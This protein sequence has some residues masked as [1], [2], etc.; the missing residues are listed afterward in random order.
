M[1]APCCPACSRAALCATGPLLSSCW[2][3]HSH[4]QPC[5]QI[6]GYS[7]ELQ[8]TMAGRLPGAAPY[9]GHCQRYTHALP[10]TPQPSPGT[11][12]ISV[13]PR[14]SAWPSCCRTCPPPSAPRSRGCLPL[15][16]APAASAWR[17]GSTSGTSTATSDELQSICNGSQP[18][19][20]TLGCLLAHGGELQPAARASRAWRTGSTR[21][22]S[23]ATSD[24]AC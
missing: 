17:T 21:G 24:A 13:R 6:P 1:A 9:S 4:D 2:R 19:L 18:T 15:T 16:R 3:A 20:E 11:P 5:P 23:T 14:R 12:R 10:N 8:K 22:T 7:S